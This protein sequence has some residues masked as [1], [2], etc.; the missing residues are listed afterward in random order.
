MRKWRIVWII[1]CWL[2]L[3]CQPL[4]ARQWQQ[5]LSGLVLDQTGAVI[6]GAEVTLSDAESHQQKT[7]TDKSGMFRFRR[8]LV[9]VYR[10]SVIAP[11][12]DPY[13]H[14]NLQLDGGLTHSLTITLSV[15]ITEQV[16]IEESVG[17]S[18]E[19][20]D[21]LSAI[22]LSGDDLAAL[23]DDP[24]E[25][26]EVLRQMAGPG[27]GQNEAQFYV[28]GFESDGGLPP[29]EAIREIRI[30]NNPFSA[31]YSEPGFGR[32]EIL[33]RPGFESFRGSG[34]FSFNDESLNARNAFAPSRAPLQIRRFGGFFGG[35]IVRQR[36]SF[37]ANIE[38]RETDENDVVRATI[39]DPITF[40][41]TPFAAT[42][43]T[44]RRLTRFTVRG[45][46]QSTK[47]NTLM[48]SYSHSENGS[49]N[50]GIGEFSL[51]EH[52]HQTDQREHE[53]RASLTTVL[54]GRAVNELRLQLIRRNTLTQAMSD[55]P[56]IIVQDAFTGG[57][58]QSSLFTQQRTDSVRLME[59]VSL[60]FGRHALKIG[61]RIDAT[62]QKDV[63]RSN[64]GGTFTF[65]SLDQYRDVLNGVPGV[66]PEQFSIN[67]GDPFTGLA[68]WEFS[69]FLQED[70]RVRPNLTLS[71]GM[72]HEFQTN[73]DDQV[74]FAPRLGLAWSPGGGRRT[75]L[76]GGFGLFYD[77]LQENLVLNVL[78]FRGAQQQFIIRNPDY[79][80]PFEQDGEGPSDPQTVRTFGPGLSTPYAMQA[81]VS[82][83]RQLPFDIVSSVG[84]SWIRGVHQFRSRNLNAP[85]PELEEFPFP[86]RGPILALEST[87]NSIRHELR[88]NIMR[89][90]GRRFSVFGNY[91]L[92]STRSD[93]DSPFSLPA[94]PYDLGIEWGR[95]ATDA[96]HQVF[97]GGFVNLPWS[98][99]FSPFVM[100]RSG[101]PFNIT[102]GRDNNG[103]TAFTDRPALADPVTPGAILTSLGAFDPTPLPGTP[104][105]PRNY[106]Q[107]PGSA[108]VNLFVSKSFGFGGLRR[109]NPVGRFGGGEEGGEETSP[110]SMAEGPMGL[111]QDRPL[112]GGM[113]R[114]GMGRGGM[115]GGG[116]SRWGGASE[117]RYSF[118]LGVRVSNLFNQF[119]PGQ[120]SGV[121]T[122]PFFG[123][124]NSA[125]APRRVQLDLRF[126]F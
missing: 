94:N 87:A 91:V 76:R 113:G 6:V 111:G 84:Y 51:P 123:E 109:G 20:T 103:D 33:T 8:L 65:A 92:S 4:L 120:F 28:D 68:Q 78:R 24:D 37:L 70:W 104:V 93:A 36:A 42:V 47:N 64:F 45:D 53:I 21:N 62:R 46:V 18:V 115:G 56:Q 10:L 80:S 39:L 40:A 66:H 13:I 16:N 44:P 107:G 83:E 105:I 61:G 82:V 116:M 101:R 98:I 79:P 34:S 52:G 126:N 41:P 30:N 14:E 2:V 118:T 106:G 12:F 9:S 3:G 90:L 71:L 114:G 17:V 117:F 95:A 25:L 81:T 59:Q 11:G 122:S 75:V 31:E 55:E 88:L 124:A 7:K 72:R 23:P 110:S 22:V 50:Q 119:N 108:N 102:T 63:N 1:V 89:R 69:W 54:G 86:E 74:N 100:L 99:R 60:A 49:E 19:P 43:L 5:E 97:V 29:K 48:L 125:M 96:R 38:R 27:G 85:L 77:R 121:I 57:G 26:M 15:V 35:P 73:L 112:G 67:R 32:I 58:A